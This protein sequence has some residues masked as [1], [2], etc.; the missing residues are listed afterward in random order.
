MLPALVVEKLMKRG[1][2]KTG[3]TTTGVVEDAA[4]NAR[5]PRESPAR[6]GDGR[7]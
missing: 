7:G 5:T 3:Q 4:N 2:L 6:G 1:R